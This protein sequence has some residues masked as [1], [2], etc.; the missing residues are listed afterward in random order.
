MFMQKHYNRADPYPNTASPT[1]RDLDT[2]ELE[3]IVGII[4]GI[5]VVV[6]AFLILVFGILGAVAYSVGDVFGLHDNNPDVVGIH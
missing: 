2:R 5:A 6:A 1:Q 3:G 4:L